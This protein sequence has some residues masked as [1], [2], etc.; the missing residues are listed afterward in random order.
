MCVCGVSVCM[1]VGLCALLLMIVKM[2]KKER[3]LIT[4]VL[5]RAPLLSP[6]KWEIKILNDKFSAIKTPE[7]FSLLLPGGLF[8]SLIFS[9]RFK[10]RTKVTQ[11][12]LKIV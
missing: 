7:Y 4:I 2:C 1:C 3:N 5:T 9:G 12:I 11:S 8:Q 6:Q 10:M